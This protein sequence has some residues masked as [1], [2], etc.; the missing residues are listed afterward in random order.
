MLHHVAMGSGLIVATVAIHAV[1][2]AG[3]INVYELSAARGWD[4]ATITAKALVVA[5][6]V[7]LLCYATLAEAAVWAGFYLF[8]GAI[9]DLEE[10]LYFS[11]VTFTTLGYGDITLD[12]E[13]RLMSAME[14]AN[15]VI[16]LGWTT[17]LVVALLQRLM[18]DRLPTND[19]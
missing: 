4:R 7:L 11:T 3:V 15:G 1:A 5:A 14:S 6:V 8:I 2:T 16:I 18:R 10:A 12:K 19:S 17:A 13:W 9:P